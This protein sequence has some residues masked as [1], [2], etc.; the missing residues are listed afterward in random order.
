MHCI[1]EYL[2][3]LLLSTS[4]NLEDSDFDFLTCIEGIESMYKGT[5]YFVVDSGTL[6][7]GETTILDCTSG[8][9]ILVREGKGVI[10]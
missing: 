3:L 9:I 7:L 8:E 5:V 10:D 1:L 4:L 6:E 2:D